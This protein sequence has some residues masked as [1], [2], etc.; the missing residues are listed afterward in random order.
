M[1][2]THQ[3][4]CTHYISI[5]CLNCCQSV[6][7]VNVLVLKLLLVTTHLWNTWMWLIGAYAL[8]LK[9]GLHRGKSSAEITGDVIL[10]YLSWALSIKSSSS[11]VKCLWNA[12][13]CI[14][15]YKWTQPKIISGHNPKHLFNT[16]NAELDQVVT[17]CTTN[18]LQINTSKTQYMVYSYSDRKQHDNETTNMQ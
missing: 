7:L 14:C 8:H 2:D 15:H 16:M 9:V 1:Q 5:S 18:S 4:K 12:I 17:W 3:A 10:T 6:E 13:S 11:N